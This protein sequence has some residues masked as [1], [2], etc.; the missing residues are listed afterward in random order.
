MVSFNIVIE[1]HDLQDEFDNISQED[2]ENDSHEESQES[3]END[4]QD[5]DM[6]TIYHINNRK[7]NQLMV[8]HE[9]NVDGI[10]FKVLQE[11]Q[12]RAE[13]GYKKYGT[14]LDREDLTF[15]EWIQHAKEEHMDAILYLEKIRQD[16]ISRLDR[17]KK[18]KIQHAY[19]VETIGMF[20]TYGIIV[21]ALLVYVIYVKYLY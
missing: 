16:E 18:D 1:K 9:R 21:S 7:N 8:I 5:D 14:D 10:V 4:S 3:S 13:F 15:I 12:Q 2:S 20:A 6:D 11:F 17:T 19:L